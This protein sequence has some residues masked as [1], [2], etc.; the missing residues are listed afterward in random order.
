[1][2]NYIQPNLFIDTS[3][4]TAN[5]VDV[6][7]SVNNTNPD[8]LSVAELVSIVL[9]KIVDGNK[10]I[11]MNDV[12]FSVASFVLTDDNNDSSSYVKQDTIRQDIFIKFQSSYEPDITICSYLERIRKYSKCSDAC[13]ILMLIY[14][15]RLIEKKGLVLT[16]LNIHR[17]LI[18]AMMIAAKYHDDLFYNNAYFAKLGGLSLQELNGLELEV[19]TS[20]DYSMFIAFTT[21]EKYSHQLYNYKFMMHSP[22]AVKLTSPIIF[23]NE[24]NW[25]SVR[26][27][28]RSDVPTPPVPATCVNAFQFS[29]HFLAPHHPSA[30]SPCG[31]GSIT[32]IATSHSSCFGGSALDSLGSLNQCQNNGYFPFSRGG[33]L[34][35]LT[36]ASTCASS[37][38]ESFKAFE[39]KAGCN[40]FYPGHVQVPT[41]SHT[42]SMNNDHLLKKSVANARGYFNHPYGAFP[43]G[44]AMAGP[45]VA[46]FPFPSFPP[47]VYVSAPPQPPTTY[48]TPVQAPVMSTPGYAT[49]SLPVNSLNFTSNDLFSQTQQMM[50]RN[51]GNRSLLPS[52]APP[53]TASKKRA[54]NDIYEGNV[55]PV[56]QTYQ[57]SQV[58]NSYY[59]NTNL[60]QSNSK[61]T[62][63]QLYSMENH[64]L[65][66]NVA[67]FPHIQHQYYQPWNKAFNDF[68][69]QIRLA[70]LN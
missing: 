23:G 66:H 54:H 11:P 1:M 31:S 67:P 27:G 65:L 40:Y 51:Y 41:P 55:H 61:I 4:I 9:N 45:Q 60:T 5:A 8:N 63:N 2:V 26:S 57:T 70:A 49:T 15:D 12:S 20:L 44:V 50:E 43:Q 25:Q 14:I 17:L 46:S 30:I 62:G 6:S 22:K 38:E 52:N 16:R 69:E 42:Q 21:Y 47:N 68:P 48:I 39:S 24:I 19:L 33:S 56:Y 35:S 7:S 36:I 3:F 29:P 32:S 53:A 64:S 37:V 59:S 18:T 10:N 28:I 34:D 13:F 58:N